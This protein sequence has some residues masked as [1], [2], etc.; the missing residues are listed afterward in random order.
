M[1][2]GNWQ[3]TLFA[4]KRI[5]VTASNFM[6]LHV[7]LSTFDRRLNIGQETQMTLTFLQG[8]WKT[9]RVPLLPSLFQFLW[10]F[11]V[12][13]LPVGITLPYI[14]ALSQ[15]G[16]GCDHNQLLVIGVWHRSSGSVAIAYH[17]R[18]HFLYNF[19]SVILINFFTDLLCC[20][21]FQIT[22]YTLQQ[23]IPDLTEGLARHHPARHPTGD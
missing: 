21:H 17:Y 3:R 22:R 5:T 9:S 1:A 20:I 16:C 2:K 4:R 12:K 18:Q 23:P 19:Y 15:H 13:P 6:S 10:L 8:P 11:N 7:A 14:N